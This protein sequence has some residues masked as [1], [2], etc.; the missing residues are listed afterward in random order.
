MKKINLIS[1]LF[2]FLT[3]TS[4][5]ETNP[6]KAKLLI[7]YDKLEPQEIVIKN[8]ADA[9]FS[10][11]TANFS[12]GLKSIQKEFPIFLEGNLEDPNAILFLKAFA[13]DTFCIRLN[14]LQQDKFND[15]TDLSKEI[16]SV[17]QH[18]NYYYPEIKIPNTIYMYVSGI[19]YNMPSIML[20]KDGILISSDF[21]LGNDENIYDYVGMPRFRSLRCQ[22]YYIG[23]DLAQSIYSSYLEKN[24]SQK[25]VLAEMI[26]SGKRLYFIEAMNPNLP[27][28]ILMG[29]SYKQMQ[30]V[31][32]F[33]GDVWASLVGNDML[34]ANSVDVYR[35]L[36]GD[37]PFTQ[38]YSNDAPSRLGEYIGLQIIRSYMINNDITLQEL[39]KN[40]DIQQIFQNSQ[41]KPKS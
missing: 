39:M 37:G 17:C 40:N 38:A 1:M 27:D 7:K 2:C 3:L 19:D 5:R 26:N 35:S 6:H 29:Y 13:T 36:F 14:E 10:I 31:S 22:P 4:C 32:H 20:Q 9:L 21:Y 16:K 41:Y 12:E 18:F 23:R 11:D 33:E 8:Y 15:V 34:Y 30:W 25:D 24:N 28:S